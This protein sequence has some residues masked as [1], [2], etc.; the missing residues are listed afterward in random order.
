MCG[1]C[2]PPPLLVLPSDQQM[3]DATS[4][5]HERWWNVFQSTW[6]VFNS[7][8]LPT[9]RLVS[10]K[11]GVDDD[12]LGDDGDDDLGRR[13]RENTTVKGGVGGSRHRHHIR[14]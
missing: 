1:R 7:A 3:H 11:E 5:G 10:V 12:V 6:V 9:R 4:P 8:T 13:V 14:T 2:G